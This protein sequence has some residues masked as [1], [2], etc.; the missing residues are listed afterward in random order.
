LAKTASL[1]TPPVVSFNRVHD[2]PY[3]APSRQSR[4]SPSS[5]EQ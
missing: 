2:A 4:G 1:V 5:P 3:A